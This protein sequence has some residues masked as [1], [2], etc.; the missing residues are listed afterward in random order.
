MHFIS[1]VRLP[2]VVAAVAL[3]PP[4]VGGAAAQTTAPSHKHYDDSA[5]VPT[6][7]PGMPLAPRLQNLGVH[8]FPVTTK[9][10]RAQLFMNQGLNLTYGFNHAEAARAYAEA[11]RLDPALAMAYWGQAL[12][13]GP[14]INAPMDPASEPKALEL[15]QQA[16][17][18]KPKAS[19]RERALIDAL[20][21]RYTGKADDRGAADRAYA[22]AMRKVTDRFPD[23]LDARTLYAEA[24]MDL[25]PWGYFTRDGQPHDET[26]RVEAAL[27]FALSGNQL[28]PGALHLWIHLWE[29]I[30]PKRA[31]AEADRLVPLMPGAGH[32]VHMP[33]HIYQRVGRHDD[34]IRVNQLAAKA[35]EDYIAACRAQGLYPLA[36]YPH[37]LHFIWMGASANG[38]KTLAIES[39]RKLAGAVPAEGLKAAPILQGFLVV[40]YYAMVRFEEW[41][42]ILAE[43]SPSFDTPF[44]GS[45]WRYARAMALLN[46]DRLHDAEQEFSQ[47]KM[48]AA[49]PSLKG[50]TTFSSN[51]GIAIVQIGVEIVAGE[52]ARQRGDLDKAI[53]HFDRAVRFEDALVYTEPPDWHV[54][55]RQNLASALLAANRAAEAETVMW[56]DLK[57]NAEHGWT[58]ALLSKALRAQDKS[59]EAALIDARFAKSWKGTGTAAGA[60]RRE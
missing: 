32:M 49:D 27:K 56:E 34:V 53:A 14:N 45:I 31:E 21:T 48:L 41:D 28:H 23:D 17:A 29:S 15:I 25:R 9:V 5:P 13:L 59:Q 3:F 42:A 54:P 60:S 11:A 57:R 19:P 20:A 22:E 2:L 24:L 50:Q 51:S 8:R 18:L 10:E 55:S 4:V 38:Q 36:Y 1:L 33:A 35:D 7:A 47:L 40:P 16:I 6:P 12:V 30:D 46:R 43:P 26:K 39:A 37:N 52:I 58:L 44:T